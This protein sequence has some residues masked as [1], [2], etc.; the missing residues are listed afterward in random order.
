M[1]VTSAGPE[2][3]NLGGC[4][5]FCQYGCAHAPNCFRRA[6]VASREACTQALQRSNPSALS[7]DVSP[8]GMS[9][10]IRLS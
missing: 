6:V 5:Q 2:C 7:P 3:M 9:G 4:L 8:P 10:P 1:V